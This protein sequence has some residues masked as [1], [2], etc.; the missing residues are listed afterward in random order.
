M[1]CPGVTLFFYFSSMVIVNVVSQSDEGN[2]TCVY[3]DAELGEGTWSDRGCLLVKSNA[4]H[5]VCSCYHLSSFAVLMALYEFKVRG[6]F[7]LV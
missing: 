7:I 1:K 4:T 2:Y 3:W 6:I 5:T